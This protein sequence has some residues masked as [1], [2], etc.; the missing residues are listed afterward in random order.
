MFAVF[1][2]RPAEPVVIDASI[3]IEA[4]LEV[5]FDLLDLACPGN[6]LRIQGYVFKDNLFGLARYCATHADA[7]GVVYHF[8]L[9]HYVANMEIGFRSWLECGRT[10]SAVVGSRSDYVL[11]GISD[12]C[13]RLELTETASL[14]PGTGAK[15]AARERAAMTRLVNDHLLRLKLLAE[16]GADADIAA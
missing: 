7:P 14:K 5:V 11:V 15:S 12:G 13:C 4:P 16:Y 10:N 3:E 9:D 8:D 2:A 6:A 1:K